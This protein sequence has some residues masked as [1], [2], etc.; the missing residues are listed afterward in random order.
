MRWSKSH[1][2]TL[3]E[4]PADADIPSQALMVRAGMIR[5]VAPGIYT[6]GNLGLRSIRKFEAIVREELNRRGCQ[7]I[8]MPMVQPKALWQETGRWE[9]MGAGL[10][11]FQNR[12]GHDFCLGA[13]H[14]EIVTDYARKDL[15]SYRGLPVNLYQIQTKYRDEIRPRFGLMRG[16]EFIMKDA[17]SFDIDKEAA[18]SSYED[19]YSAYDAIFRRLGLKF[20]IV[21]A[22]TGDMGG[23]HSHE[24]QVLAENGEDSIMVCEEADYSANSEVAPIKD[25]VVESEDIVAK[26]M[27]EF[28]T[29]G[30]RTIADL[31]K[32]AGV[33]AD[34]LVKTM[35]FS[36][37]EEGKEM[38]AIAV[39][40]CGNHEVNP[41]KLKKVLGLRAEPQMLEESEVKNV[42]GASPGS[43][44]PVG[45]KIPIYMDQGVSSLRNYIVGA[46]KDDFHLRNVNHGRD[47]EAKAVVDIR[48]ARAGDHC[49]VGKG[50]VYQAFRGIEVGQ[51][52]CLGTKYSKSMGL[53]FL[54]KNG[55]SQL[56]EMGCYGIGITRTIQAAVEQSHDKDGIVWPLSIAPF[57]VHICSLDPKDEK[58]GGFANRLYTELVDKGVEVLI[59]DR[60]ERPGIKFKDAD[61]IGVPLRINIGKRGFLAGEIELVSRKDKAV[62]KRHPDQVLDA[63]LEWL[64]SEQDKKM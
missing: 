33:A 48:M 59:D 8:L 39:L 29:P 47:F 3:R 35:F 19:M 64:A 55:K 63:V 18:L 16:R 52:F 31:S 40:L 49:P 56:V 6:Y 2:Y 4:D 60:K 28:S 44:G 1:I 51:V 10:L 17:Y 61:L 41:I 57:H 7:E 14:E 26:D 13:T 27:E 25:L 34:Q 21:Q 50:G 45:L 38:T 5:K 42:T 22:D 37:A 43:C 23:D 9:G 36:T 11:K 58:A 62:L 24:F 54:D 20:A 12:N 53:K 30:L 46:N 15:N 32:E